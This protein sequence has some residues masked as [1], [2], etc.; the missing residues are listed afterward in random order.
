M[1]DREEMEKEIALLTSAIET[2]VRQQWDLRIGT[3][4]SR[5]QVKADVDR[6]RKRRDELRR[7]LGGEI[8]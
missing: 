2:G 7:A 6:M 8:K 3:D 1:A 4:A 5:A